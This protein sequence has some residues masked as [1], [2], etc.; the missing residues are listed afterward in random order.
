MAVAPTVV[1][2]LKRIIRFFWAS[3]G[4]GRLLRW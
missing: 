4:D 2:L 1:M 3:V